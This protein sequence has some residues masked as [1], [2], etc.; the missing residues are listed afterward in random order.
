MSRSIFRGWLVVLGAALVI[1]FGGS[2]FLAAGY[3]ILAAGLNRAFGWSRSELALGA[4][5]F[6]L[7][8]MLAY[9]LCGWLVD[10]FGPRRMALVGIAG[11]GA[12]LLVAGAVAS[13]PQ[14]YLVMIVMGAVSTLTN[15]L[16]YARAV[17][18]W[19][20]RRRGLAIGLAVGGTIFGA[21]LIPIGVE[22]VIAAGDW[23]SGW[24]AVGAVQLLACLPIVA[25][26]VHDDPGAFGLKPDGESV[27]AAMTVGAHTS[28]QALRS[29]NFW[30]LAL[31]FTAVGMAVFGVLTNSVQV[32]TEVAGLTGPQ[33][34]MAQALVGVGTLV[35]RVCVGYALDRAPARAIGAAMFLIT[36]CA[37][38]GLAVLD[39][40]HLM[41]TAAFVLG[42][43]IGGEAD[44]LPYMI[45]RYFGV[46]SMG[47]I[48]GLIGAC[49]ALGMTCGPISFAVLAAA[50][51]SVASPLF[52]FAA[53]AGAASLAFA[54][55]TPAPALPV[56]ARGAA[57]GA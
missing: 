24:I 53:L 8:Q 51:G 15:A 50:S 55:M 35:G 40:A 41:L 7:G 43:S 3:S 47:R 36:A 57:A 56:D 11:F 18:M 9:P 16:T 17:S 44:I 4:T 20:V 13:L 26:L 10:R 38:A 39:R 12:L 30:L 42:F 23:A 32:M 48:Y 31:A 19:F 46:T 52:A 29:R 6:M 21:V 34:A 22:R 49:F 5:L 27:Q 2:T 54:L 33:I 14:F 1:G 28:A 45:S 25:L 37:I